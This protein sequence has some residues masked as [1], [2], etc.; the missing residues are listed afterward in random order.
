MP[1]AGCTSLASCTTPAVWLMTTTVKLSRM[2]EL[3]SNAKV[4]S[5]FFMSLDPA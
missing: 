3:P 1:K 2:K 5:D 4:L